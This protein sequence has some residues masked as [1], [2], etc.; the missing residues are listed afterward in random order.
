MLHYEGDDSKDQFSF[1]DT[2]LKKQVWHFKSKY[3][4]ED[5]DESKVKKDFDNDSDEDEDEEDGGEEKKGSQVKAKKY[6]QIL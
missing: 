6:Y 2:L 5:V 1:I 3:L 4:D